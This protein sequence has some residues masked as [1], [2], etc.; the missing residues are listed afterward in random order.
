MLKISTK[1]GD[2]TITQKRQYYI[3]K[4]L[5]DFLYY[6]QMSND[7]PSRNAFTKVPSMNEK[8]MAC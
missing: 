2:I 5:I 3:A 6:E 8:A 4:T 7:I 1:N